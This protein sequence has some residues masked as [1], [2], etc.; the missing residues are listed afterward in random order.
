M[1][2]GKGARPGENGKD[3]GEEADTKNGRKKASQGKRI[4]P[5]RGPQKIRKQKKKEEKRYR[6]REDWE[7]NVETGNGVGANDFPKT[8]GSQLKWGHGLEGG[9]DSCCS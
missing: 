9:G 3:L 8:R 2:S 6:W 5:P 4:T 1:P 7:T